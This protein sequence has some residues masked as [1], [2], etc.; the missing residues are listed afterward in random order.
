MPVVLWNR[1][2]AGLYRDEDGIEE[3]R[4]KVRYA[5]PRM[6][7]PPGTRPAFCRYYELYVVYAPSWRSDLVAREGPGHDG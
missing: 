4:L 6:L 3:A 7:L 1:C 5:L 2:R